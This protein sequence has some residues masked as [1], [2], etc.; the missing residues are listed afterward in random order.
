VSKNIQLL[1]TL[2]D[3]PFIKSAAKF[4]MGPESLPSLKLFSGDNLLMVSLGLS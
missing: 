2:A 1:Q 4:A 3:Y